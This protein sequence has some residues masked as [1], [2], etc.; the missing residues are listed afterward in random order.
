[1]KKKLVLW[2]CVIIDIVIVSLNAVVIVMEIV[3]IIGFVFAIRIIGIAIASPGLNCLLSADQFAL[4][5][6]PF[7]ELPHI[8]EL[9]VYDAV[10]VA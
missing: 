4:Q 6:F 3:I 2:V 8:H 5:A 7:T 10:H 1:M 9:K